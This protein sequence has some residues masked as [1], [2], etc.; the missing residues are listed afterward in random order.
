MTSSVRG[1][2]VGGK[3][4]SGNTR[5]TSQRTAPVAQ[6][7]GG[8]APLPDI[9][10]PAEQLSPRASMQVAQLQAEKQEYVKNIEFP[11]YQ[12]DPKPTGIDDLQRLAQSLGNFSNDLGN[13]VKAGVGLEQ[14]NIAAAKAHAE[15]L[16]AQGQAFGPF[17]DY[18][19]LVRQL[20]KA[21]TDTSLAEPRRQQAES[22]LDEVR[23]RGNRIKPYITSEA[24][25][26]GVQRNTTTLAAAQNKN[27][28]VGQDE[29]GNDLYLTDVSADDSRYLQWADNHIF[30]NT[31]LTPAEHERVKGN[32]SA[33]R[34]NAANSHNSQVAKR[35]Q[36]QYAASFRSRLSQ[37]G[38]EDAKSA[39]S[40]GVIAAPES[41]ID[42]IQT[43]MDER[44]F[45]GL[46]SDMQQDLYNEAWDFYSQGW[47]TVYEDEGQQLSATAA[48]ELFG[49]LY[50]GP[51][52]DR[53]KADGT[54]N[55][56]LR[57]VNTQDADWA[58]TAEFDLLN[59]QAEKRRDR[60]G[61][62]AQQILFDTREDVAEIQSLLSS[63]NPE[64]GEYDL[65]SRRLGVEKYEQLK[66]S[67]ASNTDLDQKV[68]RTA[69]SDLDKLFD[70]VDEVVYGE[71]LDENYL[72]AVM[73]T[74]FV[75]A[76][77]MTTP[78]FIQRISDMKDKREIRE[79][80]YE[81]LMGKLPSIVN[82]DA[83]LSSA[84]K[85]VETERKRIED[86][87]KAL[88]KS[89]LSPTDSQVEALYEARDDLLQQQGQ[90]V[91]DYVEGKIKTDEE[92]QE[93]ILSIVP[94]DRQQD[95]IVALETFEDYNNSIPRIKP[96][97]STSGVVDMQRYDSAFRGNTAER[98]QQLRKLHEDEQ[99]I[100]H[101]TMAVRLG[102]S[103]KEGA[104]V[105][106][107][108]F[109]TI[110][111][112]LPPGISPGAFMERELLK[113]AALAER[114]GDPRAAQYKRLAKEIADYKAPQ[115]VSYVAP[116]AI[117][118]FGAKANQT[119]S[120]MLD[121]LLG[122][123]PAAAQMVPS[124]AEYRF[125]PPPGQQSIPNLVKI[126]L[127]AGFTPE[128][129][130]IAAAVSMAE[131]SGKPGAFNPDASTGDKSYGLWQINMLGGMGPERRKEFG[132]GRDEDL[133]NPTTNA[134]AAR[135]IYLSQG[136]GAW[137]VTRS[138]KG[139]PPA[140]LQ[141]LPEARKALQT[142]LKTK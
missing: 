5:R 120:A 29:L 129:A 122:V 9:D 44:A 127:S 123:S 112:N 50:V 118:T 83:K 135:K 47:A 52:S 142:V 69:I 76:G 80:D 117:K 3:S 20:E 114:A 72:Q 41:K 58:A 6:N 133:W 75:K 27:P 22:L 31:I 138:Y 94:T 42:R 115:K 73:L 57:W 54:P 33:A 108:D 51:L 116:E 79:E 43:I 8:T 61:I 132:L 130:A 55:E 139:A 13:V 106:G 48:V 131:S 96:L 128:E 11:R 81:K 125:A 68:V 111:D 25:I 46:P 78:D 39:L 87:I 7:Q 36:E 140:Y 86:N 28:I 105:D 124:Q 66:K 14:S 95:Q 119:L 45:L 141:Y 59:D 97:E 91:V 49:E 19:A 85:T 35:Q 63:K 24:R 12:Q 56:A 65:A 93:R 30:G 23:A 71:Q 62:Q 37:I 102:M 53:R 89:G 40:S 137:S 21:S 70:S 17:A 110:Q 100:F 67:L 77:S 99:P 1:L 18:A 84:F 64:T 134:M 32:I 16:A 101:A 90:L 109:K 136:W 113:V 60:R 88:E 121:V 15:Q 82:S 10:L 104:P 26:L 2:F 98:Q 38:E 107:Y 34:V 103:L 4:N 126:A 74:A 92:L